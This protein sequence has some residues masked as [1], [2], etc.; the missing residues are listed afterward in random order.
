MLF[1]LTK[2]QCYLL[3]RWGALLGG[4]YACVTVL[5]RHLG[6]VHWRETILL[7]GLI[8]LMNLRAVVMQRAADGKP[9][10]HQASGDA[11]ILIA[12]LS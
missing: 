6:E 4:I 2:N 12:L 9:T 1:P 3:L 10:L 5:T 7:S 8:A 11:L